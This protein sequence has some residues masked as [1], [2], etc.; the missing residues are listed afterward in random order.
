MHVFDFMEKLCL[1]EC[2]A[3]THSTI[4]GLDTAGKC[5]RVDMTQAVTGLET[6]LPPGVE[7]DSRF[8]LKCVGGMACVLNPCAQPS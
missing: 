1:Q 8:P 4:S 5:T 3:Y 7:R 6:G 2:V